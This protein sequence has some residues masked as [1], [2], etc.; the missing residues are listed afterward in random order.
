V[1]L[2][3]R[4]NEQGAFFRE[5][6]PDAARDLAGVDVEAGDDTFCNH[7]TI[8]NGVAAGGKS[9]RTAAARTVHRTN[10]FTGPLSPL[11]RR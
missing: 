6:E 9:F 8:K 7:D 11:P 2:A 4:Y 10:P 3:L 5:A 1:E